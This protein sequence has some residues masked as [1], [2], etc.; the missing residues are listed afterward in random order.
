M[1]TTSASTTTSSAL[2]D[3]PPSDG[4][5]MKTLAMDNRISSNP[6]LGVKM[7][8]DTNLKWVIYDNQ[9]QT[10]SFYSRAH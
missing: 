7:Y 10:L 8:N 2:V 4:V 6:H 1:K 3:S 9:Q 5:T